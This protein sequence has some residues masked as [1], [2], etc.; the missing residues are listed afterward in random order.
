MIQPILVML[1]GLLTPG[2][3]S[4]LANAQKM[5]EKNLAVENAAQRQ[6][7]AWTDRKA[8]L[9][10][11][12][13]DLTM[14]KTWLEYQNQKYKGYIARE[15]AELEQLET[16]KKEMEGIN[17]RLEPY[18]DQTLDQLKTFVAGDLPFLTQ[19]RAKRIAFLEESLG[20]YHLSLSE[21]LRRVLEALQVEADYG[22][23]LE[24]IDTSITLNNTTIQGN[25]FRLGRTGLFFQSL[26]K[27]VIAQ[28]DKATKAWKPL[29]N[30]Y[31]RELDQALQMV[32]R[33]R[34]AQL[35]VFPL[36]GQRHE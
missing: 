23:T 35:L 15:Q 17:M 3:A 24:I 8:V 34:A 20:D 16:R 14:E 18:L 19:E 13:R 22:R 36:G 30:D 9:E 10:A 21:K 26:D 2:M 28:F 25:V 6:L 31:Q 33:K 7:E 1:L 32:D 11:R 29:D 27:Q 4:N 5:V 12:I